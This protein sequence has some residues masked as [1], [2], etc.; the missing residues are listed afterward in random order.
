VKDSGEYARL[1]TQC[2]A[3]LDDLHVPQTYSLDAILCWVERLRERPLILKELPGQGALA[4]VCGLW[5]AAEDSDFVFYEARTAGLHREHIILHE[6]G[7]ML[8]DHRRAVHSR[9]DSG[10]GGLLGDRYPRLIQHLMARTSYTTLEE[11][12]A[13]MLATLIQSSRRPPRPA[14][15]LGQLG[16]FLG[17]SEG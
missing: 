17:V 6:I 1:Q 3:I 8:C 11:Q 4:G 14:G 5:L 9:L 13:E 10:L 12:Q 2:R 7:H 15:A 16:A